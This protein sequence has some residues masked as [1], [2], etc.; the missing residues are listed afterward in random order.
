LVLVGRFLLGG[1]RGGG[2][3]SALPLLGERECRERED[4]QG[5][6]ERPELAFQSH[7]R[8]SSSGFSAGLFEAGI[9]WICSAPALMGKPGGGGPTSRRSLFSGLGGMAAAS[10]LAQAR[11]KSPP[12]APGRAGAKPRVIVVGAG[13][14]GGW[15]A[16][17][18]LRRGASVTLLDAWG[19]GNSRASSGG[20]TRV[21]RGV[22]GADRI[23]TEMVARAFRLWHENEER[24]KRPLYRRTGALWL[25]AD[26]GKYVR[27]AMPILRD[28]G[29]SYEE[30]ALA[31]ASKRFPQ[32][33]V[34]GLRWAF[35]EKD[36]G[37]LLAR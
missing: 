26:D 24:W 17:A 2:R 1:G 11:S 36:A 21:T 20:E 30:L 14:F 37:Y 6:K 32:V 34:E 7:R 23:Y 29:F 10:L 4:C 12:P 35:F 3:R 33:A 19:P 28:N 27:D 8:A 31:D 13:A 5:G 16:L 25:L 18:L 15:T 9:I 22:D